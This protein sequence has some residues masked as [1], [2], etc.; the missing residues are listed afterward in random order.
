MGKG[1]P[2]RTVSAHRK[3][4]NGSGGALAANRIM[5]I[6]VWNELTNEEIAITHAPISGGD[7]EPA[8]LFG[9]NYQKTRDLSFLTQV[10]YQV[11]CPA[12][13]QALFVIAEPVQKI[14]HRI[15]PR[16]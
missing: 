14:K 3:T 10:L 6:D 15:T 4:A 5:R 13:E 9:R 11:P 7:V 1:E 12:F 2:K 8:V 16:R